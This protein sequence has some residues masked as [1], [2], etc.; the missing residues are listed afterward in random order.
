MGRSKKAAASL[1]MVLVGIVA[2]GSLARSKQRAREARE[3][4]PEPPTAPPPAPGSAS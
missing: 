3:T 1:G 4:K 2:A